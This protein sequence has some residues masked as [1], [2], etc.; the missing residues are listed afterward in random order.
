MV[1]LDQV[2]KSD[3]LLSVKDRSGLLF[4]KRTFVT[5]AKKLSRP[6]A[7]ILDC[8]PMEKFVG[9][10]SE[11]FTDQVLSKKLALEDVNATA[12]PAPRSSYDK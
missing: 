10:L 2:C 7:C 5:K 3:S 8:E 12:A 4:L 9:C 1:H 11:D 6:L